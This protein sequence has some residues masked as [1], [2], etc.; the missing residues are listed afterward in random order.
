MYEYD[1]N[2]V[3]NDASSVE[4]YVDGVKEIWVRKKQADFSAC[5]FLW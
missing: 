2:D 4:I 1:L 3:I 5:F